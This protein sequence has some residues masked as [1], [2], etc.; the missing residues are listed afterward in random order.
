MALVCLST[1]NRDRTQLYLCP[2]LQAQF[3]QDI[4]A[5]GGYDPSIAASMT[6]SAAANYSRHAAF[7][8]T[9]VCCAL[10]ASYACRC[11][12]HKFMKRRNWCGAVQTIQ[13]RKCVPKGS[14][15][16]A[17]NTGKTS[18]AQSS[19]RTS[20]R[21]WTRKA[22]MLSS[23]RRGLRRPGCWGTMRMQTVRPCHAHRSNAAYG[24]CCGTVVC[25]VVWHAVCLL[26]HDDAQI[27]A[28][29]AI[30][31]VVGN[32]SPDIA[33]HT[34]APAVTVPMSFTSA[35][36]HLLPH[37]ST[38]QCAEFEHSGLGADLDNCARFP[39]LPLGLQFV[40]RPWDEPTLIRLAYAYEQA[41]HHRRPPSDFPECAVS[42]VPGDAPDETSAEVT[43]G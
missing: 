43:S 40:G 7:L 32:N 39:G 28:C 41:T 5:G 24:H 20:S 31:A 25:V 2:V 34:G 22:L 26:K 36:P 42:V 21:R 29:L 8:P 14:A 1:F 23:T 18:V 38:L 16:G 37:S 3:L 35:G 27:K 10:H 4:V 13:Q 33:P 17:W 11:N 12:V 6:S 15:A 30:G 9:A 19:A